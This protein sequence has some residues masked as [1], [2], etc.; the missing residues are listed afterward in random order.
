[1]TYLTKPL[2]KKKRKLIFVVN[3]SHFSIVKTTRPEFRNFNTWLMPQ[4][5]ISM[6]N[7]FAFC[8]LEAGFFCQSPKKH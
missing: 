1:M 3:F 2:K 7:N 4:K 8:P 6:K 5:S